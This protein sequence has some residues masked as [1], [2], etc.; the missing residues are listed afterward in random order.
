MPVPCIFCAI[1]TGAAPHALVWRDEAAVAFLDV[2]PVFKGHVLV[3]PA[4]HFETLGDL[5]PPRVEPLFRMV[6]RIA[7]GVER[8]LAAD[9][10]FVAMNNKVSQ[11]VPH[12]HVHVIPRRRKDGLKGFF[13]PRMQYAS[14]AEC[15]DY[16]V[17][18]HQAVLG[19]P[20]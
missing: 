20:D 1:A 19:D 18:I 8:G 11:S 9:G 12:L 10:T 16:A 7:R 15:N 3:I 2:R 17:R 6:R 14:I 13:W 5:D 4:S